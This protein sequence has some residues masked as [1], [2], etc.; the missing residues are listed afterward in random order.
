MHLFDLPQLCLDRIGELLC[1]EDSEG[2]E[3]APLALLKA[4]KTTYHTFSYVIFEHYDPGC[5]L[6]FE[7]LRLQRDD[8]VDAYESRG[9]YAKRVSPWVC[10]IRPPARDSIA[11][12]DTKWTRKRT[13]TRWFAKEE[14]YPEE[15]ARRFPAMN[16]KDLLFG[17]TFY[18]LPP[19]GG[20]A[21]A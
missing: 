6:A 17:I 21:K 10:P 20:R 5:T 16:L 11:G 14:G 7:E 13:T 15:L 2:Y 18:P 12:I 9:L 1:E 19:E 8:E 4:S 3:R